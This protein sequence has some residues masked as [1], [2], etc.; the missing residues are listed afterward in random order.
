M[1][2][3]TTPIK[4]LSRW[5]RDNMLGSSAKRRGTADRGNGRVGLRLLGNIDTRTS[6]C[7]EGFGA[8]CSED[9]DQKEI[10]I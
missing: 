5:S 2:T 10:L 4:Y 1:Q 3:K 8:D 9:E 6:V 7:W